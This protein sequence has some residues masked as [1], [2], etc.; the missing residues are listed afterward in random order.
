MAK[1]LPTDLPLRKESKIYQR[2]K[3]KMES[4]VFPGYLFAALNSV[5]IDDLYK[6]GNIFRMLQPDN[7]KQLLYELHQIH[8]ALEIDPGLKRRNTIARGSIVRI[9]TG[10]FMGIEGRV[11]SLKKNTR[12]RLNIE[13]IGQAIDIEIDK[14]YIETLN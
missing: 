1:N 11:L 14:D 13:L 5:S 12:V 2:R 8:K 3:I 6:T 7:E 9:S 4:P 10:P